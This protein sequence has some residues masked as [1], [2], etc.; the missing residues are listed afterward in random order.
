MKNSNNVTFKAARIVLTAVIVTMSVLFPYG[1][2]KSQ[3]NNSLEGIV[4][5][6]VATQDATVLQPY[7][8]ALSTS[9]NSGLFHSAKVKK[10]FS[11]Y[12]GIKGSA[13]YINCDNPVVKDANRTFSMMP[14]AVPQVQ[15]GSLYSTEVSARFMPTISLGK[16]GSVGT[17]GIGIK[18]GFT[19]H[20]KNSPIDGAI[21]FAYNRIS[22][23]DSKNSEFV[24]AS[25]MAVNLQFSKE[26]SVFTFYTGVQ[27]EKTSASLKL[28]YQNLSHS[29][30]YENENKI[31]AIVGLN[32]K[33]GPVNI[34]SDYSFG[35]TN[36]VSAG[37][38][39]G[40]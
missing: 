1:I 18:H 22:I 15:I 37:F 14:M 23:N 13:S 39:F 40:F 34:N 27:Y 32:I 38:G 3:D 36:S 29:V 28:N 26:L 6:F 4:Q 31:K 2:L 35:K 11:F 33:L 20:F 24:N 9:M 25:S 5:N 7:A 10:G 12:F 19:S 8:D 30:N 21:G 16:Y 17:W